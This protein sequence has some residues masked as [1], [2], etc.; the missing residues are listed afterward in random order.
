MTTR[1]RPRRKVTIKD[2]AADVGVS[3]Q[4]ISRV[5]NKSPNVSAKAREKVEEAV[6]RLGYSPSLA[7]RRM[8]GSKSFL[9]LALNDRDR[10][11][12]QWRAREGIDWVDQM[13]LGGITTC[14]EHGYRL[15]LELVDTHSDNIAGELGNALAALRPDGVILTPPHSDN[16]KVLDILEREG[17]ACARIGGFD[18]AS[19]TI[20]RMDDHA[21]AGR[22]VEHLAALGHRRIGFVAG[23]PEYQLSTERLAGYRD[24][25]AAA[26]LEADDSLIAEGDFGY[27]S[28]LKA[29]EVLLSLDR[30]PTAIIAS[31][32]QMALAVMAVAR[33]KAIAMPDQLSVIGFDDTPI[34][35]TTT[36]AL[37]AISQPVA[38][39]TARAAEVLIQPDGDVARGANGQPHVIPFELTVRASTGPAPR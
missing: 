13:L 35:R 3:L 18:Q 4:T 26:G 30:P 16:R 2:V 34:A 7:A 33:D 11:I 28:G 19:G 27:A 23:D 39:M 6:A 10:T 21:A 9:L 15:I 32:D 20:I 12:E 8:G 1:A 38:A 22:C 37:T 17:V 5:L 24:A 25:I 31:S 14:A 36:P 29:A